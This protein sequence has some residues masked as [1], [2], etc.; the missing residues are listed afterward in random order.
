MAQQVT[1]YTCPNCGGPVH[2]DAAT[3]K[4]K[5]DY[6]DSI[7]TIEE[8]K[9]AYEE[10]NRRAAAAGQQGQQDT[11]SEGAAGS[12]DGGAG[13]MP[14]AEEL[15]A[16]APNVETAAGDNWGGDTSRLKLYHCSHCGAE[17]IADDTTAATTCPYCGNPMVIPE[18]F[19][20]GRRP[21]YVI[22]FTHTKEQAIEGLK[23]YYNGKKLLPKSFTDGNHLQEIKGVY[24]PYWLFGGKVKARMS[25]E[26]GISSTRT[27]GDFEV[28]R[29]KIYDVQ[30]GGEMYFDKIPCDASRSMPDDL[31]D[32][33]EPFDYTRLAQ[34]ELEYLPGYLANKY[35]VDSKELQKKADERAVTTSCDELRGSVTGYSSV[36]ERSSNA[37][38]IH[39]K[40]DYALMPVWL[41]Y[42]K[43]NDRDF[44]FAMNG[45]TGK[46]TGN[47]PVDPVKSAA[48]FGGVS[49]GVYA[50][51]LAIMLLMNAA[52]TATLLL[53]AL[54][55]AL[56]VGGVTLG[57]M[58]GQMRPV[59]QATR[60]AFYL[61]QDKSSVT[62]RQ[63]I[64]VRT[65]E[66]R[67]PIRRN[68]QGGP[69]SGSPGMQP[70]GPRGPRPG[71]RPG[72]SRPGGR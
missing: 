13:R 11:S 22:P 68:G 71:G 29:T 42:T 1:N 20:V 50:F 2:F 24:V 14:T 23:G 46:M 63:D 64:Y 40:T 51:F 3:G 6:C 66:T 8:V 67:T 25:F 10:Q 12:G 7:F 49:A 36:Q 18:Q 70:G 58:K 16:S 4:V 52:L 56:V 69:G 59:A 55:L 43:W 19:S 28:T 17:L 72:G 53:I 41:L 32:S 38:V 33:I 5:C 54:G 44:L 61:E 30:R 60:A 47:L 57:I 26:C 15:G 62:L 31:M 21:D 9:R 39:G 45:Q 35:D 37:T 34:F 27:E 65:V 48:W